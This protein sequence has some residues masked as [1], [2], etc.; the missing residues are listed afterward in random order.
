MRTGNRKIGK[1][2]RAVW[3]DTLIL[4][5]EFSLPLV[6]FFVVV[7]G[8]GLLYYNISGQLGEPVDSIAESIYLV[9]GLMFLQPTVDFPQDWHLQLFFF[10]VPLLGI[11]AIAQG[12]IEFTALIFNRRQRSKEWEMAVASTFNQHTIV[13]GV[14]HLGFQAVKNLINMDL[15]V[16]II[17]QNPEA[18]LFSE[19]QKMGVPVI[20]GDGNNQSTLIDARVDSAKSLIVCT[21]N[22]PLNMQIAIKAKALNSDLKIVLRIFD[23]KFAEAIE[24]QFNFTALS[25]SVISAPQFAGA[26]AG[27]EITRPVTIEGESYSLAKL[28]INQGSQLNGLTAGDLEQNY[29]ASLVVIKRNDQIESHPHSESIIH[30]GN[31]IIVLATQSQIKELI[32]ANDR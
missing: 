32:K 2:I 7:I 13:V 22:D 16:V 12:V 20:A 15:D 31:T 9:L 23:E 26:A 27:I 14:G 3:R 17:E 18:D 21:Q 19:A 8:G 29:D 1:R 10:L 25:S 30:F 24:T 28:N 6:L 11:S 5:R 4:F